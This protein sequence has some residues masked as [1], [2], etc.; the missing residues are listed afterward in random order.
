M[1]EEKRKTGEEKKPSQQQNKTKA[2]PAATTVETKVVTVSTENIK[3]ESVDSKGTQTSG[4]NTERNRKRREKAKQRK[5][6]L[7][8]QNTP[9][10]REKAVETVSVP[11]V[12][13]RDLFLQRR[14]N[15]YKNILETDPVLAARIEALMVEHEKCGN[16]PFFIG[17]AKPTSYRK[18]KTN[19]KEIIVNGERIPFRWSS[20]TIPIGSESGQSI[21]SWITDIEEIQKAILETN[22]F[23]PGI[24]KNVLINSELRTKN[25]DKATKLFVDYKT[26]LGKA[27]SLIVQIKE[28]GFTETDLS[29]PKEQDESIE[30]TA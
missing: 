8:A 14:M 16:K 30:E 6:E 18:N 12:S 15:E 29:A 27:G 5:A 11:V 24:S 21:A 13:R 25:L 4:K 22:E 9:E 26:Q 3:G 23:V 20:T 7:V 10:E 19:G 1:A 28:L 2:S 17:E